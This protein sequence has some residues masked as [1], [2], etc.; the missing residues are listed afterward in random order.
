MENKN[1]NENQTPSKMARVAWPK[2][3]F[4]I[5]IAFI[6]ILFVLIILYTDLIL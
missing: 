5:Y 4:G 6:I 3:K 2:A 1:E